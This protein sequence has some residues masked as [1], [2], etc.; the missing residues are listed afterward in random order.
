MGSKKKKNVTRCTACGAE[1]VKH[2]AGEVHVCANVACEVWA[3]GMI[4]ETIASEK[5]VQEQEK[6]WEGAAV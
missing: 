6:Y 3:R 5:Y 1:A 2:I 4:Q